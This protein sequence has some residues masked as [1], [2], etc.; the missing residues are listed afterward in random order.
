TGPLPFTISAQG[1]GFAE[2]FKESTD[3]GTLV[4]RVPC[5]NSESCRLDPGNATVAVRCTQDLCDPDPLPLSAR[6]DGILDVTGDDKIRQLLRSVDEIL[7]REVVYRMDTN[8]LTLRLEKTEIRWGPE[9]AVDTSPESGVIGLGA[10]PPFEP[11][12][13]RSGRVEMD[14]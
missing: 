3:G 4:R 13:T 1:P 12:E 5:T 2:P 10:M 11:F 9:E 6:V 7:V 14:P 8:S